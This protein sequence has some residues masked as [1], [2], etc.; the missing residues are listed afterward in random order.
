MENQTLISEEGKALLLDL[1]ARGAVVNKLFA[2]TVTEL[3]Q[4][5]FVAAADNPGEK[6]HDTLRELHYTDVIIDTPE[7]FYA[8]KLVSSFTTYEDG[9]VTVTIGVTADFANGLQLK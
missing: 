1:L 7:I 3:S 5:P 4:L 6:I 2:T 9:N 8:G